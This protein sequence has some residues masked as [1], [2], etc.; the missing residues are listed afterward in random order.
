MKKK[1]GERIKYQLKLK[2][3]EN[4]FGLI[5]LSDHELNE[6]NGGSVMLIISALMAGPCVKR[7]HD[8]ID[9]VR[10]GYEQATRV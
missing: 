9:G 4:N 3:M 6:C 7:L 8:F 1:W 2:V 5:D 10:A